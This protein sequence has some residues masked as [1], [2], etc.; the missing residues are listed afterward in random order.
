MTTMPLTRGRF[1]VVVFD[2][3]AVYCCRQVWTVLAREQVSHHCLLTILDV[4]LNVI[5]ALFVVL[6]HFLI[7]IETVLMMVLMTMTMTISMLTLT[8]SST[9][10]MTLVEK[11]LVTLVKKIHSF[12]FLSVVY[13]IVEIAL[14]FPRIQNLIYVRT[15]FLDFYYGTVDVVVVFLF[16][17]PFPAVYHM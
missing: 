16:P 11:M 3:V 7:V 13:Q 2:V 9:E 15:C 8:V 6:F 10:E 4:A 12:V 1:V 5:L 14:F 17:S